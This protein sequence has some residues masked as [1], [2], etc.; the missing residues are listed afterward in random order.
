MQEVRNS[1]EYIK[2][3]NL[4]TQKEEDIFL[5]LETELWNADH[6]E[7]TLWLDPGRIK[8][9]LIPNQKLGIPIKN[10]NSYELN[11]QTHT[12]RFENALQMV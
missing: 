8:K 6:T 9:D 1:L 3:I 2:V 12:L 5:T 11:H 7:L 4:N 10:G